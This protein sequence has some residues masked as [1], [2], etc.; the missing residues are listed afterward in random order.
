MPKK[1][2]TGTVRAGQSRRARR[3]KIG[4]RVRI[5]DIS[6]ELKDPSYDR[7]DAKYSEMRTSELFRFCLGRVFTIYGFDRYG[8][9]E[10]HVSNSSAVRKRFGKWHSIWSEPEFLKQVGKAH[11]RKLSS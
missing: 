6:A 9:V 4:D 1:D 8:N 3:F 5:V 2:T 7:Q 11:P 10:L